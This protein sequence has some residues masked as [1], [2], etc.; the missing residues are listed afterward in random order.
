MAFYCGQANMKSS[1]VERSMRS[2]ERE[3][4]RFVLCYD[5]LS[6]RSL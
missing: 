4:N 5:K 3:R 2:I 6:P 1:D